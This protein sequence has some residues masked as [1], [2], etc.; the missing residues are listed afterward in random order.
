MPIKSGKLTAQEA[1]F[2]GYLAA[3]DDPTYAAKMARYSQ[4]QAQGWQKSHNP[5]IVEATR[6]AQITRLNND[7]LPKSLDLLEKVIL[8]DKEATRN[9]IT[10]AQ[11]VLKYSLG[12]SEGAD[13]KEPHE[14]TPQELQARID[15]LRRAMADKARPVIE[16]QAVEQGPDASVFD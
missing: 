5:A 15:S 13:S 8:D 4:P 11:T 9:R 10:A 2:I 6:K 1:Q 14:M 16:G 3:T 12:Q 7:L